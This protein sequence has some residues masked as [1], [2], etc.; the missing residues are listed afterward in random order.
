[1]KSRI[2]L[3]FIMGA[4]ILNATLSS[5]DK[6]EN[7]FPPNI[8]TDLDTTLFPGVWSD[9]LL[10]DWPEFSTMPNANPDRNALIEDFTGH[11]CAAC[12]AAATVAH[13]LLEGNPSRIF[14]A[15]MHSSTV[16]P[17]SFQDV[18]VGQGY[19]IDFTNQ[20]VFDIGSYFGQDVANSGF[21]GNPS[22][23]IN[24]AL[25]GTEYFY[26]SG[27]WSTKINEILNSSLKIAIKTDVNYYDATKGLFLH[28]EVEVLDQAL[29]NDL[30]QIVYLMEDSLV[31]PQNVAGALVSDYVHRDIMRG[32]LSG[33]TWGRELKPEFLENGKY[34]LDYSFLVPDQLAP[35]GQPTTH[36]AENMHLL[37]Y[38]YDISTYEIYQVIKQKLQ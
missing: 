18:N 9:Y 10:N 38:V 2:Y 26:A 32:T 34:Y 28:T 8:N 35:V 29:T 20:N 15:S 27:L 37:I 21:F 23:T 11:N 4:L 5:C 19:T 31:G 6:I 1:M 3:S 13:D 30:G 16:G 12:P 24:R 33:Q 7:P 17:S 22:G 14:V 25:E 36:N